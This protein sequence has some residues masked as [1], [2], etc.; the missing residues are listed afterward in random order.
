MSAVGM[1]KL[2]RRLEPARRQL[3][4][5]GVCEAPHSIKDVRVFM[6]HHVFAEWDFMSLLKS[7]QRNLAYV[8]VPW[9]PTGSQRARRLG[10]EIV[11][12][13]ES[14]DVDGTPNSH[15]ELY[16]RSMR[17]IDSNTRPIDAMLAT[18]RVRTPVAD[19]GATLGARASVTK[20][21]EIIASGKLH[22]VAA[23]IT[24]GCEVPIPSMFRT[25]LGA[26][27]R[28]GEHLLHGTTAYLDR[29]IELDK[30]WQA[31]IAIEM[32]VELC[33]DGPVEWDEAAQTANA[34]LAA[35]L[36]LR[37]S[38]VSEVSLGRMGVPQRQAA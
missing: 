19:C 23:A 9:L 22:M 20:A 36:T 1:Y 12:D 14:N 21:F 15:F 13:V 27:S 29:H 30:D 31:P 11:P 37:S 2:I 17:E 7:L 4:G 28:Q 5:R 25:L 10:N 26:L 38:V 18:V 6:E 3:A 24:F 32:I 35:R 8:D 16:F 34:V 33:G